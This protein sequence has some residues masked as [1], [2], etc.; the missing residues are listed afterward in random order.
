MRIPLSRQP[1]FAPRERYGL[2]WRPCSWQGW[3]VTAIAVAVIVVTSAVL[4]AR[5]WIPVVIVLPCL[6]LVIF[7]TRYSPGH[8]DHGGQ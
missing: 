2:G 8:E 6:F 1:W 4:H 5:A 7:L 3:V